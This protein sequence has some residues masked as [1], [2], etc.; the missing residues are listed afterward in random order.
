[1]AAAVLWGTSCNDEWKE[2]QYEHYIAF[3]SPLNNKGVTEIYVPYTRKD[4]EPGHSSYQLPVIVSGTTTN[5]QNIRAYVAHDP[6]TLIDLNMARFQLREDLFYQD[7]FRA[8]GISRPNEEGNE[9]GNEEENVSQHNFVTFPETL[10]I[11][12]GEDVALLNISF[13]FRGID[14]SQKWVLPLTVVDNPA[15]G[16]QAHPRKNYAKAI[17][18]VFPFNDFSGKYSGTALLNY[19]VGQEDDGAIVANE[20]VGYVVDEKTIFFYAGNIDE[21]R[22]DR[23]LYKVFAEF[24]PETEPEETEPEETEPEEAGEDEAG[25]NEM[26]EVKGTVRFY[27]ED[28]SEMNFHEEKRASYVISEEMDATRPYLKRRYLIISGIEYFYT[29]HT[30]KDGYEF[31]YKVSG[32][33]TLERTIN[34]QIPDEDQAF[35]W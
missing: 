26:K 13:D 28:G 23:H 20:V 5:Q 30:F 2:E 9:E 32:I 10:D 21:D 16:Y 24:T 34:T 14:M 31:R 17:L 15:Y 12:A 3:R 27:A 33:L 18:R 6:D 7:L 4:S 19:L 25:G 29:D 1:L 35:E 8:T 11:K 22:A